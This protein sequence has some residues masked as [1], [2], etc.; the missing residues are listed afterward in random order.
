MKEEFLTKL[1]NGEYISKKLFTLLE[2]NDRDSIPFDFDLE[3]YNELIL[4]KEY[5]KYKDY[6]EKMYDNVESGIRLDEHQIK[7]ILADEDYSLIIAGAGTGKTTTMASKVK[8]LV[9]IKKVDPKKIV[10]MSFTK[11]A[12]EELEQRIVYDFNIPATVTTF[13]SLG[14]MHI[15]DIFNDRK[16][17]VVD[18]NTCNDIFLNYFKEKI[19][20]F[21]NK[22][23]EIISIFPKDIFSK[24][25]IFSKNFLEN[26]T[27][28][29]SFDEYFK[30]YKKSRIEKALKDN[31]LKQIIEKKKFEGLKNDEYIYT[32]KKEIVKSRG[33][34]IIANYL[35][36]NGIEYEYE[37][38]FPE[39]MA[40]NTIYKPDFTLNFNGVNVYL[41]YFGLSEYDDCKFNKYKKEKKKKLDYH[42]NNNTNFIAIDYL[43]DSELEE[44]LEKELLKKGFKINPKSDVEIYEII[45]DGN[46]LAELYSYKDFL[47]DIIKLIKKSSYRLGYKSH[48]L[49]YINDYCSEE[50]KVICEKQLYYIEDFYEYYQSYLENNPNERGFDFSDMIF[51][52]N[53]Y[54]DKSTSDRLKFEYLIIDEYQDISQERYVFTKN[55]AD[56]NNAKVVAVGDDW[57]SI[58]GFTGS[59]ID[60]IYNFE[61]FFPGAKILE[62]LKTYRN[63]QTLIDYSGEFIM[64]NSNQIE[65]E[66]ISAKKFD[67]SNPIEFVLFD[68]GN[69]FEGIKKIIKKI[70]LN[71][72]N[73]RILI[74]SRENKDIMAVFN[75]SEFI[76]SVG[77]KIIFSKFDDVKI[78]GM[79]IHKS[80]GLT[81]DQVIV[82]GLDKKFPH[83]NSEKYWLARLFVSKDIKE[84]IEYPEERRVFYVALTRTKNKVYLL[85][86]KN[87]KKRSPFVDE[88]YRIAYNYYRD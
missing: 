58:Y 26:Y 49:N 46:R 84:A 16:C 21:K 79:T 25:F 78:D 68:Q 36:C 28:Y 6:F 45:L 47:F 76:D 34:A 80:K 87:Q 29:D 30:F 5:I 2:Q 7:A 65:K 73:D 10:V 71:N 23:Q 41:E 15:K 67:I 35:L 82:I 14:Y 62:V 53:E 57:Q 66:L 32:L 54:L 60:Y 63:C 88:I 13:H 3:K 86:N 44:V 4:D 77:T 39:M 50:E 1:K 64:R 19:F 27:N 31:N 18:S 37:K 81:A 51:Y 9:D 75:D 17:Y 22:I 83:E 33:E 72:P 8:Y 74:L 42:R 85:V 20:P 69:E 38:I 52:A 56:K 24:K 48:I 11:K 12:T 59:K 70:H 40:E 43:Q 61:K 55:V